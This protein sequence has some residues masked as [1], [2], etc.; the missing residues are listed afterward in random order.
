MVVQ[1]GRGMYPIE[2][3]RLVEIAAKYHATTSSNVVASLVK[4]DLYGVV[5]PRQ[6][7]KTQ[8]FF[9]A[10]G[11]GCFFKRVAVIA[12]NVIIGTIQI[13]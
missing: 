7:V 13:V 2:V 1:I 6:V 5:A 4:E 8:Y 9:N 3:R 11:L 12:A 10:F